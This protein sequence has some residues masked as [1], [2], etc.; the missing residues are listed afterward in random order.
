MLHSKLITSSLLTLLAFS[1]S[2][3]D[4]L[5]T[6]ALSHKLDHGNEALLVRAMQS[7]SEGD[8]QSALPILE[9]LV[10]AYPKFKLAQLIYADLLLAQSRPI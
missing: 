1:V 5:A 4:L 7:V 3:G 2:A 9:E 6:K 8:T 10:S